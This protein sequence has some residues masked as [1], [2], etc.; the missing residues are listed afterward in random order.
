MQTGENLM[1]RRLAVG[2]LVLGI[3]LRALHYFRNPSVWHDEAA[4]ILNV[5]RQGYTDLLGALY[6]HEAAPPLFLW[7][8]RAAVDWAGPSIGVLRFAPFLASCL[9]LIVFF[10]FCRRSLP[11]Q[12][13]PWAVGLFAVSDRLLW[14]ASEAKPYALDVL[15]AVLAIDLFSRLEKKSAARICLVWGL[16]LPVAIWLSYP[17]CFM[18]GG[19]IA[20]TVLRA[21][22]ARDRNTLVG[23]LGVTLLVGVAFIALAV[24][25]AKAQRDGAMESCWVTH[26]P[27]YSRPA[28]VPVWSFFSALEVVRYNLIPLGQLLVPIIAV[29]AWQL[30]RQ[31][32]H[33][34]LCLLLGP[35]LLAFV[36]ACLHKYPFGGSRCEVFLCPALVWLLGMGLSPCREW[37]LSRARPAVW[38]LT[39]LL[40]GPFLQTAYRAVYFWPRADCAGAAAFVLE[41]RPSEEAIFFNHWEYEYYRRNAAQPCG[42]LNEV[43]TWPERGWVI[44]SGSRPADRELDRRWLPTD[45]TITHVQQFE[46][47]DVLRYERLPNRPAV[48]SAELPLTSA[49]E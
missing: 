23:M 10:T 20:G 3:A 34:E 38:V 49:R 31:R 14:H 27:D 44:I 39:A 13:L 19:V 15:V 9:A 30:H 29:G 8:E 26:F 2:F 5:L 40:I 22:Q 41:Q 11:L 48:L 16:C 36:A 1:H 7:L 45:A 24:G 35:G 32:R 33:A 47:T 17:A 25:P 4:L 12:A 18:A 42:Y 46:R 43:A 28:L 21:W 6:L 37:L